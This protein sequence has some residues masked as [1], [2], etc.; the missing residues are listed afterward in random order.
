MNQ[1][2]GV[3]RPLVL[4][5]D[6]DPDI[7]ELV[8]AVL[9]SGSYH[10][11]QACDGLE[12]LELARRHGVDLAVLDLKMPRMDGLGVIREIRRDEALSGIPAILLTAAAEQ[13]GPS[14][15]AEP[16]QVLGKPFRATR[17]LRSVA[18]LLAGAARTGGE[19]GSGPVL[20]YR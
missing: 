11:L 3:A 13:L 19:A 12:A 14:E 6:D 1:E 20:D 15:L 9:E 8:T 5:A 18:A 16:D 4:V 17:L 7:R 10:V 2:D